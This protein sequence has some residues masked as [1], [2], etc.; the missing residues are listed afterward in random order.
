MEEERMTNY[1]YGVQSIKPRSSTT[2]KVQSGLEERRER[3]R[4]VSKRRRVTDGGLDVCDDIEG[5]GEGRPG[6]GEGMAEV[7]GG[8]RAR[9]RRE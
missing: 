6:E 2:R 7:S 9:A 4:I 1:L 5:C 8:W 3:A